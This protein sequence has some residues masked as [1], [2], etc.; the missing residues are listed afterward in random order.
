MSHYDEQREQE[1]D[2]RKCRYQFIRTCMDYFWLNSSNYQLG[3]IHHKNKNLRI[4]FRG[5]HGH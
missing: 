4:N 1:A 5:Q 3:G 2:T